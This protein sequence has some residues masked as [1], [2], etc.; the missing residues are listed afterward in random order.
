MTLLSSVQ[1]AA[2]SVQRASSC[3]RRLDVLVPMFQLPLCRGE[4]EMSNLVNNTYG[5][6]FQLH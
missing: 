3:A 5:K 6:Y 2:C 4:Q 1:R